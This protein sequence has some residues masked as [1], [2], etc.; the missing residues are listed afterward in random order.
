MK[1]GGART[2][3]YSPARRPA[4]A[5]QATAAAAAAKP[6]TV[7]ILGVPEPEMT[8]AVQAAIRHLL[9]ELDELRNEVGRLK[10]RLSQAEAL[11]DRDSLTPLLNRRAFVRE[12]ARIRTF[13]ERYGAPASLVYF[14]LDGFKAINDRHGHGAGD[15]A[16][17]AVAERL[18]ANVR[19]SDVL[20]RM[21]GD[22]FALILVQTDQ[23]TA[24]AKAAA[25]AQAMEAEPISFPGG[26]APVRLS[27]GVREIVADADP[28][29][30][31]AD[32]DAAMFAAKR[33][34]KSA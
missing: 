12:L 11:A 5:R 7:A 14:D 22:E 4:G 19:E 28:E 23:A 29:S 3:P 30:L 10:A 33:R 9:A 27:Y 17:Q 1:V 18:A 15:A 25:L 8:P 26:S 32:A 13:A 16:I 24:E 21:G 34:R 20:G 6:D 2:D 31:V